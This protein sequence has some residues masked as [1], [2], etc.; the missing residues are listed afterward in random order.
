MITKKCTLVIHV[1]NA[2][3]RKLQSLVISKLNM[4]T[5]KITFAIC[6]EEVSLE[7]KDFDFTCNEYMNI[8]DD[9]HVNIAVFELSISYN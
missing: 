1:A 7:L 3:K 2:S 9:M 4:N 6:A 5:K 8:Q